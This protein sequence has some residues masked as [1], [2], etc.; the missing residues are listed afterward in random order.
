[1]D[2]LSVA[3]CSQRESDLHKLRW[4]RAAHGSLAVW[5]VQRR[6]KTAQFPCQSVPREYK[7]WRDFDKYPYTDSTVV[8]RATADL[9]LVSADS[10]LADVAALKALGLE[11][12]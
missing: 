5:S 6:S 2:S 7:Q 11:S 12:V 4:Q 8:T 10:V 3:M 9:S 1:M